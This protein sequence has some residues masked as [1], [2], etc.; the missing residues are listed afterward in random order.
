[1]DSIKAFFAKDVV[2]TVV[3][4]IAVAVPIIANLL[5]APTKT[6]VLWIWGSILTPLLLAFGAL[7]GGTSTLNSDASKARTG[8]LDAVAAVANVIKK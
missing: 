7:S 4:A 8:T 2:K 1:M 3:A 5:P 6:T